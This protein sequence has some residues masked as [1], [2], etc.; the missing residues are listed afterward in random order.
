MNSCQNSAATSSGTEHWTK[1]CFIGQVETD[2]DMSTLCFEGTNQ[3][4]CS[5]GTGVHLHAHRLNPSCSKKGDAPCDFVDD[6]TISVQKCSPEAPC[7]VSLWEP[8]GPDCANDSEASTGP[9]SPPQQSE[10]K[11]GPK[12]RRGLIQTSCCELDLVES[13]EQNTLL[14]CDKLGASHCC[15]RHDIK[16]HRAG[17]NSNLWWA[18]PVD[19]GAISMLQKYLGLDRCTPS[20]EPAELTVVVDPPTSIPLECLTTILCDGICCASEIPIVKK[21]LGPL[22]GVESV[23]VNVIGRTVTV[24]HDAGLSSAQTLADAL[25]KAALRASVLSSLTD[26]GEMDEDGAKAAVDALAARAEAHR[27]PA[28]N[29]QLAAVCWIVSLAHYGAA[30]HPNESDQA[31][32]FAWFKYCGIA[33]VLLGIF[34]ILR[35]AI[36]SLRRG[37]LDINT[38]MTIAVGGA[39]AMQDF[40]EAAAVVVLFALSDW[41]ETRATAGAREAIGAISALR[42]DE[43]TLLDGTNVPVHKVAIGTLVAVLPGE[44]VPIDG[45]VDV[46]ET[47]IDESNLTGESRPIAKRPGDDVHAGTVNVGG[48]AIRVRTSALSSNS[49]VA[50]LVRLVETAQLQTSPTEERVALFAKWYTPL[51]VMAALLFATVPWAFGPEVGAQWVKT[52]LVMLVVACP[53]ALVISTPITYVCGL[54]QAARCGILLKG[55][56][57]LETLGHLQVLALDKTGTLTEGAFRI[58]ELRTISAT[59]SEEEVLQLLYTAQKES[60]HPMAVAVCATAQRRGIVAV[61]GGCSC[62]VVKGEGIRATIS[63]RRVE[64]GNRRM[65]SRVSDGAPV[66]EEDAAAQWE[67]QGATVT[68]VLIDGV[69][70]AVYSAL[71]KPREE[72]AEA[73]E[74]LNKLG[75][76]TLMLTGDNEGSARAVQRTVGLT[77]VWS[78]LLPEDKMEHLKQIRA[79][80]TLTR[81]SGL[82]CIPEYAYVGMVGDGV[83]DTPA[84]ALASIGIAMGAA[85][86]AVAMEASD[87]ALMDSDLRKLAQ[88]VELGRTVLR[89]ITQ[90]CAFAIAVKLAVFALALAGYAWL[91]L[92][93]AT[94]VGAMIIVTLNGISVL[95]KSPRRKISEEAIARNISSR[96]KWLHKLENMAGPDSPFA[97]KKPQEF[98]S[99]DQHES[100]ELLGGCCRHHARSRHHGH[101]YAQDHGHGAGH[102]NGDGHSHSHGGHSHGDEPQRKRGVCCSSQHKCGDSSVSSCENAGAQRQLFSPDKSEAEN[103]H[104]PICRGHEH[105]DGHGH[106]HSHT[107]KHSHTYAH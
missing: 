57:H 5:E 85:G 107:H 36:A 99:A 19:T 68:W 41:L 10:S 63:G 93:I 102:S 58:G 83:N 69:P 96:G 32:I 37:V 12:S 74:R 98:E 45:R 101:D 103:T 28:W 6:V 4:D 16:L 26:S 13:E 47:S 62:E 8:F 54:A 24:A 27:Y 80:K 55:G 73:V 72:A 94:D 104:A 31:A 56:R 20:V 77:Q 46:G 51:V 66:P 7:P 59:F 29:V 87:V 2:L 81:K 38:L 39:C 11:V 100:E 17:G 40:S 70:A 71:D 3:C 78:G 15:A 42:P 1:V 33:A 30:A 18:M 76:Q 67:E 86:S 92:A 23:Q 61:P 49:A 22:P 90:N 64:I 89:V 91:W 95:K 21:C 88:A 34:P 82:F 97:L 48:V 44:R 65:L 43:A 52:A 53:C 35:R 75:I 105:A 9:P 50:R 14:I 84:L 25:N 79:D 60:A 106:D